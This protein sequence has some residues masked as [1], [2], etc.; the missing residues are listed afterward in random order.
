MDLPSPRG[1]RSPFP[2]L[3]RGRAYLRGL[4]GLAAGRGPPADQL[5]GLEG[6][7]QCAGLWAVHPHLRSAW[8]PGRGIIGLSLVCRVDG[9]SKP[10][11]TSLHLS[12]PVKGHYNRPPLCHPQPHE[13]MQMARAYRR[14]WHTLGM[15]RMGS[16]WLWGLGHAWIS[17]DRGHGCA[18]CW[19]PGP[20]ILQGVC[21]AGQADP[22]QP[23]SPQGPAFEGT[24]CRLQRRLA[25]R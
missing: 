4:P 16:T 17:L 23:G 24:R 18:A 10:G 22:A 25:N 19:A 20:L 5:G 14:A 21:E 15:A 9:G 12:T 1:A 8:D 7:G 13:S 2:P 3:Q 6:H 11:A